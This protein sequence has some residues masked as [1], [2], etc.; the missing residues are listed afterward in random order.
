MVA[1]FTRADRPCLVSPGS[2]LSNTLRMPCNSGR[3]AHNGWMTTST[4]LPTLFISHGAPL[5]ALSPGTSGPA[6]T[7][8]GQQLDAQNKP[9]G[10]VVLSP[11]WM[12]PALAV[13]R[14]P[15][16][17]TYHDFGGFPPELY[18]LEYPAPGDP[19][20]SDR[21]HALLNE[22]GFA[23]LYDPDRPL[24]H[25][26]WVPLMHLFPAAQIPVVQVSLPVGWGPRQVFALGQAL[27]PL[28]EQ[29]ILLIGS[30]SMTHN[31]SEF[32][33]GERKPDP[34]VDAFSRW[35]EATLVK[36]DTAALLDYAAQ[37]PSAKRA[38]PSDDHFLPLFF[39]VGAAGPHATPHYL[40]REVMYSMLAMDSIVFA[41]DLT[42]VL[43]HDRVG[44]AAQALT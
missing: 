16:P 8:F 19:V 13:M 29:G 31:L 3:R 34:Y 23:P 21:V 36:G 35:V 9:R 42:K 14:N 1:F 5:F 28:R 7:A 10:I 24:D 44:V 6:L 11:H 18:A 30:G 41:A 15:Q 27:H 43:A 26:V 12:T 38:H 33:G 4:A 25:G 2:A 39:A 17:E 22:A 20:L 32:F 37:A 40:S